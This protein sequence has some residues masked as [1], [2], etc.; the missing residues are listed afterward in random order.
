M[1]GPLPLLLPPAL[2]YTTDTRS[3]TAAAR[4]L[5]QR[6]QHLALVADA[7]LH[8][9]QEGTH[10][11]MHSTTRPACTPSL[12]PGVIW[13]FVKHHNNPSKALIAHVAHVSL[14]KGGLSC[15]TF[16]LQTH[17]SKAT[18]QPRSG[19]KPWR[20]WVLQSNLTHKPSLG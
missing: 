13:F 4:I 17:S 10:A 2:A 16:K 7:A 3:T 11:C 20:N 6:P 1:A 5:R 18:Q 8:T 15:R 19:G 14:L 12:R 9:V